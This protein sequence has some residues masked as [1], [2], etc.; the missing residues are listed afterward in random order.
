MKIAIVTPLFPP[1]VAKPAHYIKE[2]A[3]R[4]GERHRVTV[5]AYGHLP[6]DVSGVSF[7]CVDKR[8]PAIIR[9]LNFFFALWRVARHIDL[10]YVQNG[11]SVELPVIFVALFTRRPFIIHMGDTASRER[12]KRSKLL[13][14]IEKFA[15]RQARAIINETPIPKPELLPLEPCPQKELDDYRASWNA[16]IRSVENILAHV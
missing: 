16:H 2:L 6:E 3:K 14:Y 7:V 5:V 15:M 12:A 4:L 10:M 13:K 11:A 9:L 8:R 1:D